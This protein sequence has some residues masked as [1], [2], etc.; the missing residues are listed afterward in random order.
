MQ[1]MRIVA[2]LAGLAWV[3]VGASA[4]LF[5]EDFNDGNA[6]SRWS[7]VSQQEGVVGP[8]GG[9]DFNFDYSTLGIAPPSGSSDTIGAYIH[10][11]DVDDGPV[12]EGETYAIYPTTYQ[13]P[14]SGDWRIDA[15]MFVYNDGTAGTTEF[16]MIGTFLDPASPVAPYQ[17][18]ADGGPLAWAYTGEGGAAFDLVAFKE[19]GP[20]V[21]GYAGIIGYQDITAGTIPGFQTGIDGGLGPAGDNPRGS[22]VDVSVVKTGTL[23]EWMLNGVVMD[24]YD[25]AGFYTGSVYTFLLAASDPFNS[26]NLGT[27]TVIDNVVVIPEPA[28]LALL[29]LAGLPL[30][31][32]RRRA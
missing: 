9:V 13:L 31:A 22:W 32:R 14:T 6:A 11:N 29:G 2:I 17:Y 28:T 30:F 25:N 19:G 18:G 26:A 12:D 15:Q 16:G 4:A 8:D 3:P 10:V 24:S 27:G 21:T 23:Y 1:G 7:I 20:G 5:S